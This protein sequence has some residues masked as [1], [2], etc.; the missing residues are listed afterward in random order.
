MF[1]CLV[2]MIFGVAIFCGGIM[3]ERNN[4]TSDEKTAEENVENI[5][6]EYLKQWENL[7]NYDG[8]EKEKEYEN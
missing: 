1:E 7:L 2:S 4:D 6:P 8:N 5:D 3:F